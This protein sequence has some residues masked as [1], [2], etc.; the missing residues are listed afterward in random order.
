MLLHI[1]TMTNLFA[2]L[3]WTLAQLALHPEVLA[4]VAAGDAALLERCAL[5]S[6]RIGQCS[7]MLRTVL[8]DIEIDD[9]TTR[10]RLAPGVT[11]AT[12]LALTNT[13]AA[14]GLDRYDP[15]RWDGRRLRDE[16]DAPDARSGHDVRVRPAPLPRAALLA[17]RDH[18]HGPPARPS[19]TSSRAQ[20]TAVRPIPEQ[21]GGV[22]RAADPCPIAYRATLDDRVT[23]A[24][25]RSAERNASARIV[26]TG[27]TGPFVTCTRP[28]HDPEIVVAVHP[29]PR[30]GH[31]GRGVVAHAARARLVLTGGEAVT[32]RRRPH[33]AGAARVHPLRGA[34]ADRPPRSAAS[35]GVARPRAAR[36]DG[37]IV[38]HTVGE[39]HARRSRS[40]SPAPARRPGSVRRYAS[41]IACLPASPQRGASGACA[42]SQNIIGSLTN[43]LASIPPPITPA[44]AVHERARGDRGTGPEAVV[45]RIVEAAERARV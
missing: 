36:P 21:I 13:T 31:R 3:G 23:H 12:M 5:E 15:D 32:D 35:R 28:V 14:P 11:L 6:T 44:I 43:S 37:R 19:A 26:S 29:A 4:R 38:D 10:Y 27:F 8:N 17:L 18:P 2:A 39:R 33:P 45:H 25:S 7:V 34:R 20:F 1:A 41:R 30:I 9:G 40:G 16:D 24:A 42:V 22:A